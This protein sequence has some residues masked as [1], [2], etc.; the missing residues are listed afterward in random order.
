ME[1]I[2]CSN[3][4]TPYL[5]TLPS[6]SSIYW[7]SSWI[8]LNTRYNIIQIWSFTNQPIETLLSMSHGSPSNA[9]QHFNPTNQNTHKQTQKLTPPLYKHPPLLI[10]QTQIQITSDHQ[11]KP[12]IFSLYTKQNTLLRTSHAPSLHNHQHYLL[13][14][15]QIQLL[16][17]QHKI[18]LWTIQSMT[19]CHQL[20]V[21][22]VG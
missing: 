18:R 16:Q 2:T 3:S 8:A 6:S 20:K 14:L 4:Y 9:P 17:I 21:L 19:V 15:S 7:S 13:F 10:P 22:P 12:S 11:A 1:D 5:L